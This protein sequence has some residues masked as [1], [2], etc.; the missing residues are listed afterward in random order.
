MSINCL[1][2]RLFWSSQERNIRSIKWK[3]WRCVY[4]DRLIFRFTG[5]PP[6][7]FKR[8]KKS[9]TSRCAKKKD[10][11]NLRLKINSSESSW[12]CGRDGIHHPS[13]ILPQSSL[14]KCCG[15]SYD[16][17]LHDQITRS[18][19]WSPWTP[20]SRT[21]TPWS[22]HIWHEWPLEAHGFPLP[23]PQ[24][25]GPLLYDYVVQVGWKLSWQDRF[26]SRFLG[27]GS[28]QSTHKQS[29]F[30]HG[31]DHSWNQKT[32]QVHPGMTIT[33]PGNT[34]QPR[35]APESQHLTLGWFFERCLY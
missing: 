11:Q 7:L 13:V 14:E 4:K 12:F 34:K 31:L 22:R 17:K 1:W 2:Q 32:E 28:A 18:F 15:G 3:P 23:K 35:S 9:P 10:C 25:F 8:V 6:I 29:W 21:S 19:K 20:D 26:Y 24:T 16:V 27:H 33:T 30:C 5:D